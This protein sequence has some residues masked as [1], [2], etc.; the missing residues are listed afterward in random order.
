MNRLI[1]LKYPNDEAWI[2]HDEVLSFK[3]D[4]ESHKQAFIEELDSKNKIIEKS[5]VMIK[6]LFELQQ[7]LIQME[8]GNLYMLQPK[9]F[10]HTN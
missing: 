8:D 10:H 1:T 5:K 6:N 7:L 9:E 2:N 3:K 4:C